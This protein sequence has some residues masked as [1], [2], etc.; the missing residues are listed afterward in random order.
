MIFF[1]PNSQLPPLSRNAW[2]WWGLLSMGLERVGHNWVTKL[3]WQMHAQVQSTPGWHQVEGKQL[4]MFWTDITS[5]I[6]A[7]Y[8][9]DRENFLWT[10]SS[11]H[12]NHYVWVTNKS[13]NHCDDSC[14]EK[15]APIWAHRPGGNLQGGIWSCQLKSA[16]S[17]HKH[18]KYF[19]N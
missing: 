14:I 8:H 5:A 6:K 12:C 19:F 2:I 15:E 10:L 7:T 17:K 4:L 9:T 18:C 16:G 3:N 1:P 11:V 13:L